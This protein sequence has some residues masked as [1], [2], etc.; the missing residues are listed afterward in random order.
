MPGL[1]GQG[2]ESDGTGDTQ[3]QL[4]QSQVYSCPGLERALVILSLYDP[5]TVTPCSGLRV[6][7]LV[8][9]GNTGCDHL[10]HIAIT[11]MGDAKA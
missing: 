7:L 10:S 2:T 5:V 8:R 1:Q 3:L 6:L 9:Q 11:E 4:V